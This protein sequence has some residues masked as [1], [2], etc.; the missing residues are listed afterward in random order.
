MPGSRRAQREQR[1]SLRGGR[2][3]TNESSVISA[4][5]LNGVAQQLPQ[6]TSGSSP[7]R[8][9]STGQ[10]VAPPNGVSK[11]YQPTQ[12]QVR[13][14]LD[15]NEHLAVDSSGKVEARG[16][17]NTLY[18]PLSR[19][20]TK[21][22]AVPDHY[23]TAVLTANAA[24]EEQK[25]ATYKQMLLDRGYIEGVPAELALHLIDIHWSRHHFFL[26]TY[27]PTFYRDMMENGPHYSPLLL[28]AILAVSSRYSER[29][30]VGGGDH[31]VHSGQ[32]F[33]DKAKQLLADEMDKST[34]PTATALLLMGSALGPAG[35]V[36]KGWLY[37]GM[38]I[39][40]IMNLGLHLDSN[41]LT[42]DP[43]K[44]KTLEEV[45]IRRRIFWGAF[46]SEKLQRL[47]LGRPFSIHDRDV[48]VPKVSLEM[49]VLLMA[50]DTSLRRNSWMSTKKDKP[51]SLCLS[52]KEASR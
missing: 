31:S 44:K 47:Y 6:D 35:Q 46:I 15:V 14:Q 28:F 26:L 40:M 48:H 34:L 2:T 1:H 41:D 45:E 51:G 11:E 18:E 3:P 52:I 16:P 30:E 13:D 4:A 33:Y 20:G 8:R 17:T 19:R 5:S 24:L 22:E 43:T 12:T 9:P 37:T 10:I 38:G 23:A 32:A 39:R 21:H 29:P 36:D 49:Y 25:E 50:S 42:S 7:Q 27:R